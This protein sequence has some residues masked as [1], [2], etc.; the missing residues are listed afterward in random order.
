MWFWPVN[1]I[2]EL[3][4]SI[5]APEFRT[6]LRECEDHS[7]FKVQAVPVFRLLSVKCFRVPPKMSSHTPRGYE[8]PRLK[9]TVLDNRLRHSG[10]VVS[11]TLLP[12]FTPRKNPGKCLKE[13]HRGFAYNLFHAEIFSSVNPKSLSPGVH[14]ELM[15]HSGTEPLSRGRSVTRP[16]RRYSAT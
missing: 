16:V 6:N 12:P 9:T 8:H 7:W 13:L 15:H 2:I 11:F 4:S 10:K 14:E 5:P 1:E 3:I